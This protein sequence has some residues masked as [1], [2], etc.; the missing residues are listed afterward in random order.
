MT[1]S[2]GLAELVAFALGGSR[3]DNRKPN[4]FVAR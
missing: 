4:L 3:T 2:G 1:K